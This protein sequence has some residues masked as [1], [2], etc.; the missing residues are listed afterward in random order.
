MTH[1]NILY[2]L[3]AVWFSLAIPFCIILFINKNDEPWVIKLEE[4]KPKLKEI[5]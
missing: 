1:L 4:F 5:K 3:I 2:G